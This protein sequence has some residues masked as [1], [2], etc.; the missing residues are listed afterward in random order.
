MLF[1]IDKNFLFNLVYI[2]LYVCC[3]SLILINMI[4][5]ISCKKIYGKMNDMHVNM[6]IECPV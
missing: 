6:N 2:L 5:S 3:V 4:I 1:F